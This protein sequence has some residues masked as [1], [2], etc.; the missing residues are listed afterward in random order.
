MLQAAGY[1]RR[2]MR[3][4]DCST[5]LVAQVCPDC[6]QIHIKRANLCR[7]RLC[8]VCQWR[9][10][11]QRYAEMSKM[12]EASGD[13]LEGNTV[14]FLTLTVKNV[15]VDKLKGTLQDMS[16]AYKRLQERKLWKD[17]CLAWARSVEVT[18][19]VNKGTYHP[20]YHVLFVLN[21]EHDEGSLGAFRNLMGKLWDKCA[22]LD[23]SSVIDLRRAYSDLDKDSVLAAARESFK[24][25][26]KSRDLTHLSLNDMKAFINAIA[27]FRM[28]SYGGAFRAIR[29]ALGMQERLDEPRDEQPEGDIVWCDCGG[30]YDETLLK[31]SGVTEGY[32]AYGE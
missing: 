25:A 13:L 4:V 19:N 28:V 17:N 21:G 31:W 24:Y 15:T 30:K 29:K 9:L 16:K 6:G 12:L 27:G 11:A 22:R 5:V 32:N 18:Y 7:D 10:S 14:A 26:V 8:P 3:M 23:Y 1:E 20:H 2:A